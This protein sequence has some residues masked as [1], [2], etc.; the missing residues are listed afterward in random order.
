M[1]DGDIR[2]ASA[3]VAD[4]IGRHDLDVDPRRHIPEPLQSRR[5]KMHR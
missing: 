3:Q 1:T 5:Q 4:L 2:L